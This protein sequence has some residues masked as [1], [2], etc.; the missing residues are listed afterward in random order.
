M[1][2]LMPARAEGRAGMESSL[3]TAEKVRR[4]LKSG[5]RP[6]ARELPSMLAAIQR[7]CAEADRARSLMGQYGLNPDDIGLALLCRA[8]VP[9]LPRIQQAPLPTPE[10]F[11]AF[12]DSLEEI[13]KRASVDFLGILWQQEDHDPKAKAPRAMWITEFADDKQAA[14]ELLTYRNHLLQESGQ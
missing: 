13:T 11:P 12:A 4:Q 10:D 6:K 14:Q 1:V 5:R 9:G 2:A 3:T 8:S 7:L